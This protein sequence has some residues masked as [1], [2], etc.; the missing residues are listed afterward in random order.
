MGVRP[1]QRRKHRLHAVR[2]SRESVRAVRDPRLV[3]EPHELVA[4]D[5]IFGKMMDAG[6]HV[7]RREEG[8]HFRVVGFR[9]Q[10]REQGR[11][12]DFDFA[13]QLFRPER[14]EI[15]AFQLLDDRIEL[16]ANEFDKLELGRG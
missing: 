5:G 3:D 16:V 11:S 15:A 1:K 14:V 12:E 8:R 13:R 6:G 4:P 9:L 2:V 10:S 7:E